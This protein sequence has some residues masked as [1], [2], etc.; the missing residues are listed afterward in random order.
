VEDEQY[1]MIHTISLKR[2]RE[3]EKKKKVWHTGY[4]AAWQHAQMD[5]KN[6]REAYNTAIWTK[7]EM[8]KKKKK[9]WA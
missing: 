6:Q 5:K 8:N 2:E 9:K 3:R 7:Q 4:P 1:P